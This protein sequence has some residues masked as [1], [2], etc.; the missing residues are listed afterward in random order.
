MGCDYLP[1]KT[2]WN[3]SLDAA[4]KALH[5][6]I[7][8]KL[9]GTPYYLVTAG[10]S[11][12]KLLK[13]I[14][15]LLVAAQPAVP[16]VSIVDLAAV[17]AP[18]YRSKKLLAG[19]EDKLHYV[20]SA[21]AAL[22]ATGKANDDA[23][24]ALA[25]A[26]LMVQNGTVHETLWRSTNI[27][28]AGLAVT[29]T[30]GSPPVP[31]LD[32]RGNWLTTPSPG[33]GTFQR[34]SR[35]FR[36]LLPTPPEY[37]RITELL[38]I[39]NF[40][41]VAL[42]GEAP[43]AVTLVSAKYDYLFRVVT[44]DALSKQNPVMFEGLNFVGGGIMI[45]SYLQRYMA[46]R[47]CHF[48]DA[49]RWAIDLLPDAG[50]NSGVVN[51]DVTDCVF[52]G[53]G[54]CVE[55]VTNKATNPNLITQGGGINLDF[56]QVLD[57][58]VSRC[59]FIDNPGIDVHVAFSG[60]SLRDCTFSGKPA[61][62]GHRPY[63]LVSR[64]ADALRIIDCTFGDEPA[65]PRDLVVLGPEVGLKPVP[66]DYL[67][68]YSSTPISDLVFD[69]CVFGGPTTER[70]PELNA[71]SGIRLRAPPQGLVV[72][73]CAA[74]E[75]GALIR[76]DY[77]FLARRDI[78]HAWSQGELKGPDGTVVD[79]PAAGTLPVDAPAR[80]L[81]NVVAHC[82]MLSGVTSLLSE[83]GHGFEVV[84]AALL[85]LVDRGQPRWRGGGNRLVSTRHADLL[86][87]KD[88][89]L[90]NPPTW[91]I[92]GAVTGSPSA[93]SPHPLGIDSVTSVTLTQD[94][95]LGT[96]G[97]RVRQRLSWSRA[98]RMLKGGP[99]VFSIWLRSPD[100][101]PRY[102][103]LTI[104]VGAMLVAGSHFSTVTVGPEWRRYWVAGRAPD[105]RPKSGGGRLI[106]GS[107]ELGIPEDVL[108][109]PLFTTKGG[110]PG[111]LHL[112]ALI[113]LNGKAN[114]TILVAAPQLEL[115]DTPTDYVACGG[116]PRAALQPQTAVM[117]GS[118]IG[119]MTSSPSVG[120]YVAGD[121][122]LK[123]DPNSNG[124]QQ[125]VRGWTLAGATAP[126]WIPF[127][128]VS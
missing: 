113:F 103:A 86:G 101:Q 6:A 63:V 11:V 18:E 57:W 35:A 51:V 1:K 7:W 5:Q 20:T 104:Q 112:Q 19:Q 88:Y 9:K 41:H 94:Y 2:A 13:D 114:D 72:R 124:G 58:S 89:V 107:A 46:I 30:G 127:G 34:P 61:A 42:V 26:L 74:W 38:L 71:W 115:G 49:P 55:T 125:P 28:P 4:R 48:R 56:Q 98:E 36:I 119:W 79:Q 27:T 90:S 54:P 14:R 102:A 40:A 73:S 43:G 81:H 29:L 12:G 8:T 3:G 22:S 16:E 21:L 99:L 92:T 62:Q 15:E 122:V 84:G 93:P 66:S 64:G 117:G 126:A 116:T 82:T 59:R 109:P 25:I 53:C 69:G 47:D 91:E 87:A 52:E 120:G 128:K 95:A 108:D 39:D 118:I 45:D 37:Y 123:T 105:F 106:D 76:E 121:V 80:C 44:S 67:R 60:L 31:K 32:A 10:A 78:T 17:F 33:G 68:G 83:G 100:D 65:P 85:P 111:S 96:Q 110:N 24:A 97:A 70:Q 23:T 75:L 77:L 50:G